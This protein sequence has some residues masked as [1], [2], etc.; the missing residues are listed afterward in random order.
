MLSGRQQQRKM[1][2]RREPWQSSVRYVREHSC[3]EGGRLN[4]ELERTGKTGG[5]T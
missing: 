1:G 5:K 4:V 2:C 3:F